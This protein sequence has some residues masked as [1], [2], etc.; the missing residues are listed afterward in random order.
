LIAGKILR[1]FLRKTRTEKQF[2]FPAVFRRQRPQ[3]FANNFSEKPL[4]REWPAGY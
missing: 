2:H 4:A 1:P 3:H